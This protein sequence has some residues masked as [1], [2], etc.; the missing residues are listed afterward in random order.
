M[1]N[2]VTQGWRGSTVGPALG[3]SR[4]GAS[5][6]VRSTSSG[7]GPRILM[8]MIPKPTGRVPKPEGQRRRRNTPASYGLAEPVQAGQAGE[9]PEL[10]YEAHPMIVSMWAALARSVE[11]QFYSV[12]D[13]ERARWELWFANQVLT[14]ELDLSAK[15]WSVVQHGFNELLISPADKRR[16]GIA[17]RSTVDEDE[18]AAVH[19]VAE[20]RD[21]VAGLKSV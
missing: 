3:S 15:A 1:T 9:Q 13:W 18:K 17:L 14:G 11:G 5:G 2:I 10:G 7:R 12:A 8:C 4:H 21:R 19:Q 16:A 6:C 20:Y